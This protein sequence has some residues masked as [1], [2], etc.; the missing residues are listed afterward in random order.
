MNILFLLLLTVCSMHSMVLAASPIALRGSTTTNGQEQSRRR[1]IEG[2]TCDLYL[3]DV[4]FKP[5]KDHP[6]GYSK[7]Q[8][9]CEFSE[10]ESQQIGGLKFVDLINAQNIVA[11]AKSGRSTLTVSE[12][13]V[14]ME[15]STMRLPQDALYEI[16]THDRRK[17]AA[18][19]GDLSTLV[20]RLI[21]SGNVE[22][23]ADRS[24][25]KNDVFDDSS[26]LKSQFTACSHNKLRIKPYSGITIN[27]RAINDGIVDVQLDFNVRTGDRGSLQSAAFKSATAQIGDLNDDK[28]DIVMFCVPPG[29]GE[30]LAYAF[31]NHKFSFYNDDYCQYVSAQVHEVG[32]NLGLAHSGEINQGKYNDQTGYM[33][34]SYAAD[35]Q[36]M[37][38]NAAKSYQLGWYDDQV[39]SIDPLNKRGSAIR[40]FKLNGVSDYGKD[41]NALIV[42]RLMQRNISENDYYIGFNR[43]IGMNGNTLEDWNGVTIV[44]KDIGA[45]T[46]YGQSTKMAGLHP[47]ENY[48]IPNFNGK[49]DVQIKFVAS[50]DNTEAIIE[51]I[52][53]D[54][55]TKKGLMGSVEEPPCKDYVIEVKTDEYPA[56]NS[57]SIREDGGIGLAYYASPVFTEK[58]YTYKVEV[59]LPYNKRYKF[60]IMDMYSDGMCCLQGTG[61]YRAYDRETEE[62]LFSGGENF[63]IESHTFQVGENPNPPP[64][65]PPMD[66]DDS[67]QDK[68][69]K[70]QWKRTGKGRKVSKKRGCSS[71]A[72]KNKCE[73]IDIHGNPLWE[74]CMKSCQRC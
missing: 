48:N 44:R 26:S 3:T 55:A 51:V 7:E 43:K 56:D 24:Q 10:E 8:W 73:A 32:H 50:L 28:Y 15:D 40:R 23:T 42:L 18:K 72:R 9:V 13:I 53:V 4:L 45:P 6:K 12:A 37:C 30:W 31:S 52:D 19:T 69:G 11:D 60:E 25:L 67:C 74:S 14:D 22:P 34:F 47:G 39:K 2:T 21:D 59:C 16:G 58:F 36:R 70:F 64:D 54:R 61:S 17:L 65:P 62:V 68:I 27:N 63:D 35:D 1:L 71:I 41:P 57:W 66:E 33:G 38:F 49:S 5:N 20:I 29:T 46:E